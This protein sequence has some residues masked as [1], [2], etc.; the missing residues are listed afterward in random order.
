MDAATPDVAILDA[1]VDLRFRGVNVEVSSVNLLH[2]EKHKTLTST[3]RRSL[4]R[5][6][7]IEP[8]IGHVKNDHG[9]R[10]CWLKGKPAMRCMPCC[11]P[12]AT[13]CGGCCVRLFAWVWGPSFFI[14]AWLHWLVN[15]PSHPQ[16]MLPAA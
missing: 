6:Q 10:R 4:E 14:L 11:A 15:V 9:M 2:R 8:I 5:Q 1:Q 3:Q 12:R 16:G 7:A 13:T